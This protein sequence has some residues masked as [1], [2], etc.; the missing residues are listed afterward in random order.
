MCVCVCVCVCVCGVC[1]VCVCCVVWCVCV[2][3]RVC[4]CVCDVCVCVCACVCGVCVWVCVY[5]HV[6]V[7]ISLQSYQMNMF[8]QYT[9]LA[10]VRCIQMIPY[11]THNDPALPRRHVTEFVI[12]SSICLCSKN[13]IDVDLRML[14]SSTLKRK[15]TNEGSISSRWEE[16]GYYT[17]IEAR[18]GH[19]EGH[20]WAYRPDICTSNERNSMAWSEN[21]RFT[22][23]FWGMTILPLTWNPCT[24]NTCCRKEE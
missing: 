15:R 22:V 1:G 12:S 16:V 14:I 19:T 18:W 4:V 3:V 5:V 20:A 9:T 24:S 7:R 2:C 13:T 21:A 8:L 11:K 10:H 17:E 23:T 6:C